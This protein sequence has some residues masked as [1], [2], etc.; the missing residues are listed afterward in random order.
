M[1]SLRVL[2]CD[3]SAPPAVSGLD[4]LDPGLGW[5]LGAP[6]SNDASLLDRICLS[7]SMLCMDESVCGRLGGKARVAVAC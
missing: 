1:V 2:P 3:S 6:R 5:I 7:F 4:L